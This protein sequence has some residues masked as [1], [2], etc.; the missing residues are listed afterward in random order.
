MHIVPT[1]RRGDA[2]AHGRSAVLGSY[3]A[4]TGRLSVAWGAGTFMCASMTSMMG[5]APQLGGRAVQIGGI[6]ATRVL[7]NT[8]AMDVPTV[9]GR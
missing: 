8:V 7:R 1:A 6:C 3:A 5:P 2:D 4:K 9:V